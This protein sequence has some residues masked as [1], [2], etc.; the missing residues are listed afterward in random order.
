MI[1]LEGIDI[2]PVAWYTIMGVSRMT[3]YQWKVNISNGMRANQHVNVG[4]AKP[5]THTL[6]ATATLWLLLE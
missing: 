2:C 5:R 3:Y 1:M 6:Q 4:M